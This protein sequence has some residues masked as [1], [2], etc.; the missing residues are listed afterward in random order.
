MEF[1]CS[2]IPEH[3]NVDIYSV[4]DS[5]FNGRVSTKLNP[6]T[7]PKK[8]KDF[9]KVIELKKDESTTKKKILTPRNEL[10]YQISPSDST[11]SIQLKFLNLLALGPQTLQQIAQSLNIS[12]D[13]I[14]SLI[15]ENT[16]VYART[17]FVQD[18]KYPL[19]E[20]IKRRRQLSEDEDDL[21][22]DTITVDSDE[23]D[24]DL[25]V[26][27]SHILKDKAYKDLKPWE[28]DYTNFERKLIIANINRALTRLGYSE[29]H[30]L[31]KKICEPTSSTTSDVTLGGGFLTS[32][33]STPF[34]K[35]HT[36][37]PKL[38]GIKEIIERKVP[39]SV[40]NSPKMALPRKN[41]NKVAQKVQIDKPT[42]LSLPRPSI[43]VTKPTPQ[44]AKRKFSSSSNNTSS[45][46]DDEKHSKK[47][48]SEYTSPSSEEEKVTP[49]ASKRVEYY[50][51]LA[52]KFKVKYKE[53][54]ILYR[55]LKL[56]KNADKK[57]LVK[58]F[59]LHNNLS[60]WK[61]TLWDYEKEIKQKEKIMGLSKHKKSPGF[62]YV[63][64][65]S[66]TAR[67]PTKLKV[68]LD[69]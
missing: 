60:Q 21:V 50:A 16:Q 9:Q 5:Q 20:R 65:V 34:R 62:G 25:Y 22:I 39:A 56:D 69:Y 59:E 61:K 1:P 35:S 55:K 24:D 6:I 54:E 49:K 48:K 53:Y 40:A 13:S 58:L 12:T 18:D 19:I 37:S 28:W 67:V 45:S 46:S 23:D 52:S 41:I 17:A 51:S 47:Q 8:I 2:K 66:S 57:L 11:S 64:S 36:D 3:L 10:S 31:R 7:D 14:L 42:P 26:T 15:A 27:G 38:S 29:T 30:P 43:P 33:K 32:K 63:S 44:G 4:N 68:S